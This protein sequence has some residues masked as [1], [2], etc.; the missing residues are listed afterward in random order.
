M[1]ILV[2]SIRHESEPNQNSLFMKTALE[3]NFM[4]NIFRDIRTGVNK[5]SSELV[6]L[7][8]SNE[9]FLSFL[10]RDYTANPSDLND[11]ESLMLFSLVNEKLKNFYASTFEMEVSRYLSK[12]S[13][14]SLVK[15]F[16]RQGQV[17]HQNASTKKTH[18]FFEL[19]KI[20]AE[21]TEKKLY[22][23]MILMKQDDDQENDSSGL[24]F[25]LLAT[26]VQVFNHVQSIGNFNASP[27]LRFAKARNDFLPGQLPPWQL[28]KINLLKIIA[29]SVDKNRDG[30]DFVRESNGLRALVHCLN[31]NRRDPDGLAAQTE[32]A[33]GNAVRG[34]VENQN[35]IAQLLLRNILDQEFVRRVELLLLT[36]FEPCFLE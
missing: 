17:V 19:T 25:L 32:L 29:K 31:E 33:L 8:L 12:G 24:D 28:F 13:V 11:Q 36:V 18:N 21:V 27:F 16:I 26:T 9:L 22:W 1:A 15:L 3:R 10:L 23:D 35:Y 20:V 4:S 6:S 2:S 5:W 34:N 7:G 30:Q 14:H